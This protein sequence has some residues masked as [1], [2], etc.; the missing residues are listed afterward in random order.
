MSVFRAPSDTCNWPRTSSVRSPG[1]RRRASGISSPTHRRG[2]PMRSPEL[3]RL[4]TDFFRRHLGAERNVSRHTTLA[5]RDA[6]KLFLRFAADW[7]ERPVDRLAIGDLTPEVVLA[8]LDYLEAARYNTVPTRNA[9]LATLHG[10]FCYVLDREPSHAALCQRIL[11]I[12]VKK[13]VRPSL[14]YL[15]AEELGN[16]LGQVDRSTQGGQRDYLL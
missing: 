13:A 5:Y 16:L 2:T 15:S 12:P 10:F 7:H 3:S 4:V 11:V 14:G 9:R 6:L 8:F 1:G